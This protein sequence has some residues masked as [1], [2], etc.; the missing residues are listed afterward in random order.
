VDLVL[1]DGRVVRAS[2]DEYPDLFWAVRGGGGNFGIA[3]SFEFRLH[4]VGPTVIGGLM[5]WPFDRARE[6]LRFYR[7]FTTGALPDDIFMVAGLLTAP[8]GV[9]RLVAIG[10]MHCGERAAAEADVAPIKALGSPVMDAFGPIAYTAL[11]GMLDGAFPKGALNY[12]KSHFVD[13][14]T[15]AAIDMLIDRF[16]MAVSPMDQVFLEHFHGAPTRVPVE[17][18]AYA[19]RGTGYNTLVLA[20]WTD[21]A[22][23]ERCIGWAREGYADLTRFAGPR[24]YLNYLADDD[25]ADASLTSV[26]G[27]NLPRLRAIKRQYDPGNFFRMNLNIPPG[28]I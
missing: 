15:D 18:T 28:V 25:M 21:S 11:N 3:G 26:Y 20:Q 17:N 14:L 6:I 5:A 27:E 22:V 24:R 4:E 12:W 16:A 13:H 9:S 10:A 23:S 2:A 19:M 8:D 1:A 7:D